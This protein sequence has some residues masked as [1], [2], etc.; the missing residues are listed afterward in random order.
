MDRDHSAGT[1]LG[2]GNGGADTKSAAWFDEGSEE[3]GL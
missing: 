1:I 3:C 2:E